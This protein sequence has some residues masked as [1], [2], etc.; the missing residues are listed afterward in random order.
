MP[1]PR[2]L[3]AKPIEEL[4]RT[5]DYGKDNKINCGLCYRR[6]GKVI[7]I[8]NRH[9]PY[10]GRPANRVM[11]FCPPCRDKL[12]GQFTIQKLRGE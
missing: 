8:Q 7:K 11:T 12:I 6:T 3:E 5:E 9:F 2:H 10:Q 1:K 4:V